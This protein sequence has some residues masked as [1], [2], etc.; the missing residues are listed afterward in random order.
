MGCDGVGRLR[1]RS[2]FSDKLLAAT[3]LTQ[4]ATQGRLV[5]QPWKLVFGVVVWSQYVF[6]T[7]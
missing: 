4:E 7:S 5:P 1:L 2:L 6:N 3:F